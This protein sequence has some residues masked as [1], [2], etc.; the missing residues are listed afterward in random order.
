MSVQDFERFRHI[1][2]NAI[3]EKVR[4][5]MSLL[6]LTFSVFDFGQASNWGDVVMITP[7]GNDISVKPYTGEDEDPDDSDKKTL[8]Y[9]HGCYFNFMLK[10]TCDVSN[11]HSDVKLAATRIAADMDHYLID[12]L[13]QKDC[14]FTVRYVSQS[15]SVDA[16]A[17]YLRSF[18]LEDTGVLLPMQYRFAMEPDLLEKL[19]MSATAVVFTD[20][21]T[22]DVF[23]IKSDALAFSWS[24][25]R[26]TAYH[27]ELGFVDGIKG[28]SLCGAEITNRHK[29]IR[30]NTKGAIE[31]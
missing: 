1:W 3:Q 18:D 28:L 21:I 4:S 19:T 12:K 22:E 8:C 2:K 14:C 26:I 16:L 11:R 25:P 20:E 24:I 17:E 23:L 7:P 29:I 30:L 31:C 9:D 5:E 27:P 10:D 13:L 6:P 15:R